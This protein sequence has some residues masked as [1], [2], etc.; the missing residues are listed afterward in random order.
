MK[1]LKRNIFTS[2]V[3]RL[4]VGKLIRFIKSRKDKEIIKITSFVLFVSAVF[5]MAIVNKGP[6]FS[7]YSRAFGNPSILYLTPSG[8]V[9]VGVGEVVFGQVFLLPE[10]NLVGGVDVVLNYDPEYLEVQD[11]TEPVDFLF[12]TF[13]SDVDQVNGKIRLSTLA[14]S[15]NEPTTLVG[16]TTAVR[17]ADISFF[18]LTAG[19]TTISF[20]YVIDDTNDSNVSIIDGN[21]VVDALVAPVTELMINIQGSQPT[22]TPSPV[23]S[24]TPTSP[25]S[26]TPTP[27]LEPSPTPTPQ[28]NFCSVCQK[29]YCDDV[30]KKVEEGTDCPDCSQEPEPTPTPQSDSCSVCQKGYCDGVCKGA[31]KRNSCP[32]CSQ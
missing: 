1:E 32:D 26:P 24:P 19:T 2:A 23:P 7:L 15:G 30:C 5:A 11:I 8:Q 17:L 14:Y 18:T 10:N 27:S 12:G 21:L 6:K 4:G 28:S 13:I 31:E 9:D 3:N 25:P 29:G 16:G 20:D 22:P